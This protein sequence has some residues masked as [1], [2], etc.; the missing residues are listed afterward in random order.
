VIE[1]RQRLTL[2]LVR[3][4]FDVLPSSANFVLRVIARNR[5]AANS[6]RHCASAAVIRS[7]HFARR[8]IAYYFAITGGQ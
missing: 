7:R 8:A 5:A 1:C 2:G 6:P 4:G 3:L